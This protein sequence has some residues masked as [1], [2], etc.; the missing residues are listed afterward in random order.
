MELVETRPAEA[1]TFQMWMAV[2]VPSGE[3]QRFMSHGQHE[4][5]PEPLT[6]R[7]EL[8][9]QTT[10]LTIGILA[11]LILLGAVANGTVAAGAM[12]CRTKRSGGKGKCQTQAA[13]SDVLRALMYFSELL[14]PEAAAL[15]GLSD[16][17]FV[18]TPTCDSR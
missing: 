14:Q 7:R 5:L 3:E 1:G 10:F 15:W 11:V 13:S 2:V 6:S 16:A 17:M 8:P 9:S 18:H 12:M 4:V